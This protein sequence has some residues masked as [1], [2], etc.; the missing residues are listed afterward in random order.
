M[1]IQNRKIPEG[2]FMAM[3]QEVLQQWP[4]GR[5]VDLTEAAAYQKQ[6]KPSRNFSARLIE[7]KKEHRT[8]IQPRA[9]VPVLEEHI[10]LM[11]YLEKEG[12]ADLL[13]TTIDSYTRQNRYHEAEEGIK[14]S[15][16]EGRAMLN[17]FPAVNHG[18]ANC[19]RVIESVNVPVQIR[20]GTP[21]ARLLAEICFAG[22]FISYN[23]PYCKNIPMERTIRDWQYV[24]RLA[25]LYEEM[26]VS[27]NRE[28]YG[29]LTGTLVP[30]CISHAAAIIEAL[31]AAEQGVK[32]ITVGYG[33]CGNLEQDIAAIRTLEELTDEYLTKHGYTD[34]IVTTVLHQWMGGFPADEAKA[35]GVIATGSMIA[36]LS[37]ATKV[38]VKTPH[39]AV[40]IPT[41]E[42]NAA[43]L[44]CTKQ[45]VN[46][47]A[48]QVFR[49]ERLEEEKEIIRKET[50]AIVDKCFELGMGDIAAGVCRGVESG[51]LDVPF[52]PCRANAGLMLPARD[53][54]GCVRI[55][56]FGNLPFSQ[57]IKDFHI[58]KLEER[59]KAEGRKASFQMVIDDVYA[60]SKGRLVGRPR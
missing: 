6:Q 47:F 46:M 12:E 22:G 48:D 41:M 19:R 29:P 9:G 50:R 40:G 60:I 21:D 23:L 28:P 36:S 56:N 42:A 26:G 51:A 3:R 15:K 37:K 20:H 16:E 8:L 7:A 17:G 45:V 33:Q 13:P 14:A 49:S 10:K 25:G 39:E 34:V 54:D 43:G 57:E 32:N 1:E 31:L 4:T 27:I 11:Q 53:N 5:D 38:I 18:V 52:A 2:E 35:F 24:D 55:L 30:P 59:A 44:R 58:A